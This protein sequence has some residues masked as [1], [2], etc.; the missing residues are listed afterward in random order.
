MI[1]FLYFRCGFAARLASHTS[2]KAV[3]ISRAFA[4][5]NRLIV[6]R[7][8]F[9]YSLHWTQEICFW[10]MNSVEITELLKIAPR[11]EQ[12]SKYDLK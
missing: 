1:Q 7:I 10:L 2:L 6:N 12:L 8:G 11:I 9:M 5:N 4:E 3:G